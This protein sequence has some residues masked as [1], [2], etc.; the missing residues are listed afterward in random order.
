M[1]TFDVNT[2]NDDAR[3]IMMDDTDTFFNHPASNQLGFTA[4]GTETIR[5]QAGKLGINTTTGTNTVNI[6]GA[7]GLG[8]KFHNFTSG[9]STFITVESGDKL[10]SNVGGTG[11][12]TWVTGGAEKMRLASNGN[13]GLGTNTPGEKLDVNGD[14]RLRGNNETTYAAV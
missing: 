1:F 9:N 7:A 5:I 13:V 11:Y 10:Q 3:L 14:I 8:V 6:G 12:Y 2:S 4:G